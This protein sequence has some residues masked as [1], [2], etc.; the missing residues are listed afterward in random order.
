LFILFIFLCIH[1]VSGDEYCNELIEGINN[2]NAA[3]V[4]IVF[5]GLMPDADYLRELALNAVDYDGN[6]AGIF[7]LEP[8]KSNKDKFN[9]WYINKVEMTEPKTYKNQVNSLRFLCN[10]DKKFIISFVGTGKPIKAT[11][12]YGGNA[13]IYVPL[14]QEEKEYY[15]DYEEKRLETKLT[16][17]KIRKT[18]LGKFFDDKLKLGSILGK[19]NI[20]L[21]NIDLEVDDY[22]IK[23]AV[24]E[25]GHSFGMLDDEYINPGKEESSPDRNFRNCYIGDIDSCLNPS[26]ND[27]WGYLL[28]N[29][30]VSCIE[31]CGTFG[32][33]V[34]RS[35]N[36]SI[37]NKYFLLDEN[38]YSFGLVN[39]RILCNRILTETGDAGG[40]CNQ[41]SAV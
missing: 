37:M 20:R 3:R 22:I 19:L 13:Y 12:S 31:G 28:D 34:F 10:L 33:G 17:L 16:K 29:E 18:R 35:I 5:I 25:F 9:F 1:L 11:A 2:M 30:E 38:E 24:H 23:T 40:Y 21:S 26:L 4:N 8:F 6:N 41:F 15:K 39:E 32:K 27:K 36:N 14:N 7:S